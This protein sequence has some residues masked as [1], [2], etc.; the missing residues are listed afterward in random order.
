MAS[1]GIINYIIIRRRDVLKHTI[2]ITGG[3]DDHT[4]TYIDGEY[5][6]IYEYKITE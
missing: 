2:S 4:D 3:Y 5:I 6:N 1:F